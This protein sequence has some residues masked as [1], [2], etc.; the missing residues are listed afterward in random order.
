MKKN[1]FFSAI[2]MCTALLATSCSSDD[3]YTEGGVS[4][5]TV[6]ATFTVEAPEGISTRVAGDGRSATHVVCAVFDES[7]DKAEM[8][9]LRQVLPL[10]DKKATYKVRLAKGQSY[11][12]A[13]FAYNPG[14]EAYDVTDMKNI[15]VLDEVD[16]KQKANIESR[17]AF[18]AYTE[19]TGDQTIEPIKRTVELYRPFAQLNLGA[20]AEDVEAAKKAGVVVKYSQI[21]V[22]NVYKNFSAYDDA[23]PEGSDA[24]E[25][26]FDM[27]DILSEKLLVDADADGTSEEYEY[28]SLN[29]LLVGDKS[30]EKALTDVTFTWKTADDK[31]NDPVYT[32]SNVPVQRNYRTNIIGMLLTNPAEFNIVVDSAFIEPDYNVILPWNGDDVTEP[33]NVTPNTN[34]IKITSPAELAWVAQQTLAG[35]TFEGKTIMLMND[36]DLNHQAWTPIGDNVTNH[37]SYTFAG[38]FDGN[39][40]TISNL[41]ASDNAPSWACAGLFGT[42]TGTIKNVT[43]KNAEITSTHYAGGIVGYIT[44]ATKIENCHVEGAVITSNVE[45][46]DGGYDNGDKVGGIVGYAKS[47]AIEGCSVKDVTIN[48]YRDLGGVVGF[49][50]EGTATGNSIENVTINVDTR[51]N[52]KGYKT[53]AEFD[54]NSIVGEGTADPSNTGTATINYIYEGAKVGDS[55]YA[56]LADAIKDVEDNAVINLTE[57][58]YTLPAASNKTLTF[59][60]TGAAANTVIN[61]NGGVGMQNCTVEFENVTIQTPNG[62]AYQGL[63]H[64]TSATYKNCIF[65]NTITLYADSK[66]VDCTFE[67]SGDAYNVWTYGTNPTFEGCTFNCDGKA[68]LVYTENNNVDDVVTFNN[69]TFNDKG[70]LVNETKAAIETGANAATVQHTLNINGCTVNGFA[71]TGQN[72]TTF[73]GDNLGTELWG[74]KNQ[75]TAD[76]LDVFVNGTEVY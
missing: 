75:M 13:F 39:G 20:Y 23:I 17:D 50:G 1:L 69:C 44:D 25:M 57:G 73:G 72:A 19:I 4:G 61:V 53:E 76:N 46:V 52:Y 21:T 2:A 48:G 35:N 10:V 59:V 42:T 27:N 62:N 74:N 5:N 51:K 67:I 49:L 70:G 15:K 41:K 8:E 26:T 6:E 63:Q 38:T 11:R 32:F 30:A 31:T 36:I 16:N 56:T 66:F 47:I 43:V 9:D 3:L 65:K 71:Q 12:V 37:P 22:S 55:F 33:D 54:A 29:Y 60:G 18:T 64:L 28:L 40:K 58:T 45:E 14:A 34:E 7:K 68:V 24:S